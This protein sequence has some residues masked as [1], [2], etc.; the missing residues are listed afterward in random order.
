MKHTRVWLVC[1]L[2]SLPMLGEAVSL[3][4]PVVRSGLGQRFIA[5]VEILD[6]DRGFWPTLSAMIA[7]PDIYKEQGVEY[8]S[9]VADMS[10]YILR[11]TDGRP[12]L[13]VVGHRPLNEAFLELML[14]VGW[15]EGHL[16]RKYTI[17]PELPVDDPR[18]QEGYDG[19][20]LQQRV[21]K[22]EKR[23][24]QRKVDPA[25]HMMGT[26]NAIR[27]TESSE[28]EPSINE[29][30]VHTGR[31]RVNNGDNLYRIARRWRD[32]ADLGIHQRMLAIYRSNPDL[33]MGGNPNR[34][35]RGRW[36]STPKALNGVPETEEEAREVW[37]ALAHSPKQWHSGASLPEADESANQPEQSE[38]AQD[39]SGASSESP[40]RASDN[41]NS[42]KSA[43]RTQ[44]RLT[45]SRGMSPKELET[46][47][48]LVE[49]ENQI[50]K[51]IDDVQKRRPNLAMSKELEDFSPAGSVPMTNN[52]YGI[53]PSKSP[54]AERPA[55]HVPG[56]P[57]PS[58]ILNQGA[59]TTPPT[60]QGSLVVNP[61]SVPNAVPQIN[62]PKAT[63]SPPASAV[64]KP[65]KKLYV[66]KPVPVEESSLTSMPWWVGLIGLSAIVTALAA[67]VFTWRRQQQ[68]KAAVDVLLKESAELAEASSIF[69]DTGQTIGEAG[70][71]P[72]DLAGAGSLNRESLLNV[73]TETH[74]D[75][76]TEADV[77]I[78]YER[79]DAAEALLKTALELQ[80]DSRDAMWRLFTVYQKLERPIEVKSF[81]E[82]LHGMY[83][84]KDPKQ[85]II[86]EVL[87]IEFGSVL[88]KNLHS[89]G[90]S[91]EAE[92]LKEEERLGVEEADS[93]LVVEEK[94]ESKMLGEGHKLGEI[95][96]INLDFP[97]STE[98]ASIVEEEAKGE[99][100]K[101]LPDSESLEKD[102]L[103]LHVPPLGNEPA[104]DSVEDVQEENQP[105][106]VLKPAMLEKAE[107]LAP[108]IVVEI[109]PLNFELS[110]NLKDAAKESSPIES[111]KTEDDPIHSQ[112]ELAQ[113]WVAQGKSDA[114]RALLEAIVETGAPSQREQ[115]QAL[116]DELS[117]SN[118]N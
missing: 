65:K 58:E 38:S 73:D 24:R 25:D 115:A 97:K 40:S 100:D 15:Q 12:Y 89:A 78:T 13:R 4:E 110:E 109:P 61:P 35:V 67:G 27:R 48:R 82:R 113:A 77:Y 5:E 70:A 57:W 19:L 39:D 114:A 1:C 62:D 74:V 86:C 41:S 6:L 50:R 16:V 81:A 43:A 37:L 8:P 108:W 60:Q 32:E 91:E 90:G 104:N 85:L 118:E 29:R 46:Y 102:A 31:Y 45:V 36:I 92:P 11:H 103:E 30:P 55:E 76:L 23:F 34:L 33:F 14:D 56:Q 95:L 18:Q 17:L 54:S 47:Q 117:G 83:D 88:D 79:Y 66:P 96:N 71:S 99:Q 80:P 105:E 63:V 20:T 52:P 84:P 21:A 75:P 3:S 44:D 28:D 112:L 2:M 53:P 87:G 116:L 98:A 68:R 111:T 42:S 51:L 49:M 101:A 7:P 106:P 9:S 22:K 94:V 26:A 93:E 69:T 59:V 10:V 72:A 64:N 107:P